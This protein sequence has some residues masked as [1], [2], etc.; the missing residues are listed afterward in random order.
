MTMKQIEKYIATH[1]D[2]A[3]HYCGSVLLVLLLTKL[4]LFCGDGLG[5]AVLASAIFTLLAG[6]MKESADWLSGKMF[7]TKD[8]IAD[9][10]GVL[11]GVCLTLL[12]LGL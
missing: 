6:V 3:L 11:T 2:K 7:D 1:P 4:F 5:D 10:C 12:T 8:L 9:L